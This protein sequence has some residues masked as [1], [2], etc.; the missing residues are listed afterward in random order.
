M[1]INDDENIPAPIPAYLDQLINS[2]GVPRPYPG[3]DIETFRMRLVQHLID[4]LGDSITD[5]Q[6]F[7]MANDIIEEEMSK[8][9]KIKY[10]QQVNNLTNQNKF[11][12]EQNK[13][14]KEELYKKMEEMPSK[15]DLLFKKFI[16][17]MGTYRYNMGKEK[18]YF[19]YIKEARD[20][21]DIK[22]LKNEAEYIELQ[23]FI[24]DVILNDRRNK[25]ITDDDVSD[26]MN[27]FTYVGKEEEDF[28]GGKR[29]KKHSKTHKKRRT[30]TQKK[31]KNKTHK[32]RKHRK[33][34]KSK[35]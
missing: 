13:L 4:T 11:I 8:M 34:K 14:K 21:N 29:R 1:N 31:R 16:D 28:Y 2:D 6:A 24:Y 20:Q 27:N 19:D 23:D 15:K 5:E 32:K 12:D 25:S 9:S 10:D 30:T 3:E 26:L 17:F 7:Q 33:S 18:K 22:E 35:K